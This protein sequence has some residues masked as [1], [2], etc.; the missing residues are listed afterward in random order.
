MEVLTIALLTALHSLCHRICLISEDQ[1]ALATGSSRLD[2]ALWEQ[3]VRFLESA[4][5]AGPGSRIDL[6]FATE[7]YRWLGLT[8]EAHCKERYGHSVS[9]ALSRDCGSL[10]KVARAVEG[11]IIVD[12]P[13][14]FNLLATVAGVWC[15]RAG[16]LTLDESLAAVEALERALAIAPF[17]DDVHRSLWTD[18]I[19]LCDE[20][21][22]PDL[23]AE[24]RR[25]GGGGV[26]EISAP[27]ADAAPAVRPDPATILLFLALRSLTHGD[28]LSWER[29]LAP[30]VDRTRDE[31]DRIRTAAREGRTDAVPVPSQLVNRWCVGEGFDQAEL[32]STLEEDAHKLPVVVAAV[33]RLWGVSTDVDVPADVFRMVVSLLT[34]RRA[35]LETDYR[36]SAGSPHTLW[37]EV[38]QNVQRHSTLE[39]ARVI[40]DLNSVIEAHGGVDPSALSCVHIDRAAEAEALGQHDATEKHLKEA[41]RLL[42]GSDFTEQAEHAR[43]SLARHAWLSA[44]PDHALEVLAGLC[45]ESATDL[46]NLIESREDERQVLAEA[47]RLNHARGDLT[48][49]RALVEAHAA[50]G[51]SIMAE[52]AAHSICRE[53]RGS[54][55][56]WETKARLLHEIG[57]HRDALPAARKA[58][59]FAGDRVPKHS[60]LACILYRI[61]PE[62]RQEAIDLAEYAIDG[63]VRRKGSSAAELSSLADI[64]QL[65]TSID[66][67][68]SADRYIW[69]HRGEDPPPEWLGAATARAFQDYVAQESSSR[70]AALAP[71]HNKPVELAR[72]LTDR[73]D[74]LQHLRTE[75]GLYLFQGH[76]TREEER[77]AW[78]AASEVLRRAYGLDLRTE[79][80]RVAV[81]AVRSLRIPLRR[82]QAALSLTRADLAAVQER[83]RKG[84]PPLNGCRAPIPGLMSDRQAVE[85]AYG[86]EIFIRLRATQLA[87]TLFPQVVA[88]ATR[89][90]RPDVSTFQILETCEREKIAWIR[91]AGEQCPLQAIAED[92]ESDLSSATRE[93]LR[94][95]LAMA[96]LDDEGISWTV[97]STK[98]HREEG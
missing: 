97:W 88:R 36:P 93:R 14:D 24:A 49:C 3:S 75:I 58:L 9:Q 87:Q 76:L 22:R 66:S 47:E 94:R 84:P 21:G 1:D 79:G 33:D 63:L 73:V 2:P 12:T 64:A 54:G 25:R 48:S 44:E 51:H 68:R 96:A 69:R 61:G 4:D 35:R 53:F 23:A 11:S 41:V 8:D 15:A 71:Q 91:W 32:R 52:A 60:L 78:Y 26:P 74:Y 55:P 40:R 56:A 5:A 30:D 46:R 62:G 72:F 34:I 80:I 57:R 45:G 98:W 90:L 92:P 17:P 86:T 19:A 10:G 95:I 65:G 70:L 42:D 85:V 20:R 83:D 82:A 50:A 59:S 38:Y 13:D 18:F 6:G 77:R 16:R 39:L 37:F 43:V 27:Q 67:A 31:W 29:E 7:L 81:V 28:T 89:G